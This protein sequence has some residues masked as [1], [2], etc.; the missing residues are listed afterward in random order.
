MCTK[1]YKFNIGIQ[2]ESVCKVRVPD[3]IFHFP[4]D[5]KPHWI[6]LPPRAKNLCA[7]R[8]AIHS[9]RGLE[10]RLKKPQKKKEEVKKKK[11]KKVVV[12]FDA[13]NFQRGERNRAT[14]WILREKSAHSKT[15]NFHFGI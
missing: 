3:R 10:I 6:P 13:T 7:L 11:K 8:H 15:P 14:H 5:T 4:K 2:T 12:N 9:T 1:N